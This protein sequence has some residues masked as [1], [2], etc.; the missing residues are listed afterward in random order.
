[1]NSID[2]LN[3]K[4]AAVQECLQLW[5]QQSAGSWMLTAAAQAEKCADGQQFLPSSRRIPQFWPKTSHSRTVTSCAS[6]SPGMHSGYPAEWLKIATSSHSH[7]PTSHWDMMHHLSDCDYQG[8]RSYE[9]SHSY[10]LWDI[11]QSPLRHKSGAMRLSLH[12]W[13]HL[14]SLELCSRPSPLAKSWT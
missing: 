13:I 6:Q 12:V 14:C 1:M 8:L 9:V 2:A 10:Q 11:S 5:L 3:C 7:V 4:C